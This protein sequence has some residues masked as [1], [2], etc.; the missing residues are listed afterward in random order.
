MPA[1]SLLFL[2]SISVLPAYLAGGA[3]WAWAAACIVFAASWLLNFWQI[4]LL[5]RWLDNPRLKTVPRGMGLWR[6][7]FDTL[8]LQAKS[9]KKRKQ[10]LNTALLRLRHITRAIPNG[11]IVLDSGG[12][13]EWINHPAA[14]HLHLKYPQDKTGILKNL[15]HLPEFHRFLQQD[16]RTVQPVTL[17][18]DSGRT[19]VVSR[20]AFE[21]KAELLVTQDITESERFQ[22][23]RTGLVANVSHELR[24]PLTVING[25]L[26]T[27]ADHPELSLEQRTEFIS[28]M[29]QQGQRMQELLSDLLILAKL[30]SGQER[31]HRP[32]NLSALA[33]QAAEE[34]ARLS[35]GRHRI[36]TRIN[37]DL[38]TSGISEDL[39][40]AFSN[41][42]FNAVH[43]TPEGS[44]I[45]ISLLHN[46]EQDSAVFAVTDTGQGIAREHLDR[47][48]ER[49]YRA[50]AGRTR[51]QGGSGLGLA[52][53]KHA[54]AEHGASLSIESEVGKGSRFSVTLPVN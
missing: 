17:R 52:I 4:R 8:L 49:F 13:I 7:V 20:H 34:A 14:A 53:V 3:T 27:L 15:V 33:K 42:A 40:A 44:L 1:R 41:I 2:L 5:L 31:E 43:H 32:L 30:E 48:T 16:I 12:R 35:A 6:Q 28:L 21:R 39:Y 36:E 18:F 37:P 46:K 50:D 10:K 54:L 23:S 47:L 38:Y 29:R 11:I 25:F 22:Q 19:A 9:R 51:P 26:E 24:T 45:S